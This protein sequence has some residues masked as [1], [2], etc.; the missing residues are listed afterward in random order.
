M[1]LSTVPLARRNLLANTPRL[2]RS[3]AGIAFAVLLMMAQIG[4]RNSFLDSVLLTMRAL[5][6]DIMLVSPAKYQFENA[7]QFSRRQLYEARAVPGVATARP[8]YV[9]RIAAIWK[10]PQD[11]RHFQVMAFGFDPDQ[12]V[13]L[14]PDVLAKLEALRQPD[15]VMVDRRARSVLGE[16]S[17]GTETELAGRT[18]RVVGTFQLGRSFFSDGNVI[19][20]DRNFFKLFGA[21]GLNNTDLPDIEVGVVKVLPEFDIPHV[22]RALRDAM[23]ANVAVLTKAEWI[24]EEAR[25][26][27]Q[28]SPIGPIFGIGTLVGFAVGMMISYQILFSELSD[29]RA[30]YATLKAMGYHNRFLL[31]VV[32]QQGVFYALVGYAPAWL[33]CFL[34]F[35]GIGEIALLPIGMSI[36]LTAT[37]LGLTV[38]M[39]VGSALIVVRRVIAADPAELF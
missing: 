37:S 25:F 23:P 39:C 27:A 33:L 26:Y 34:L 16:A 36:G 3:T 20:S 2:I 30:Q 14:L 18:I 1:N 7:A 35:R 17:T 11:H 29:Q 8:F 15:T 22:Q 24:D 38:G 5:D 13:F 9:E 4:F 10:N 31:K 12:P 19:I 6:G 32:L 21:R 28:N